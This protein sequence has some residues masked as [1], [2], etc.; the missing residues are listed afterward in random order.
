MNTKYIFEIKDLIFFHFGYYFFYTKLLNIVQRRSNPFWKSSWKLLL[1][2]VKYLPLNVSLLSLAF[3][4]LKCHVSIFIPYW[5]QVDV[6]VHPSLPIWV[7]SKD[8]RVIEQCLYWKTAW[9]FLI[10]LKYNIFWWYQWVKWVAF[11]VRFASVLQ[12][13]YSTIHDSIST[14]CHNIIEVQF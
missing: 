14:N 10:S 2:K 8:I 7:Y 11:L 6:R 9:S 4:I 13:D 5:H 3:Y 1:Q 12:W